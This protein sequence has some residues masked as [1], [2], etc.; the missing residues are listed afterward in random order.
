MKP[1]D[2]RYVV[3]HMPNGKFPLQA[4]KTLGFTQEQIET[5]WV[6]PTDGQHLLR[7]V[8]DR[9]W[10][11]CST[12]PTPDDLIL[13]T[14]FGSGAGS[15]SFVLRGHR[16]A[17]GAPRT[18]ARRCARC[19]TDRAQYLTYGEYAKFREKIIVND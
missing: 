14:S 6:V 2:F 4:G 18:G 15:D 7:L 1:A 5:G 10:P 13:I 3:F 11:P 9:A 8:A 12:W 16:A 19:S 17:A